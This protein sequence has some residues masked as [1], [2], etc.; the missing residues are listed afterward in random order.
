M[1][2]LR[3]ILEWLSEHRLATTIIVA[4]VI[5]AVLLFAPQAVPLLVAA[6]ASGG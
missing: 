4:W 6:A 3:G 5:V 2:A 1:E